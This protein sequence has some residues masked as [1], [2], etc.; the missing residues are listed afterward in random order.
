MRL[1]PGLVKVGILLLSLAFT[2]MLSLSIASLVLPGNLRVEVPEEADWNV[3]IVGDLLILE[4]D[5]RIYNGADQDITGFQ[6]RIR[7]NDSLGNVIADQSGD[8]YDLPSGTWTD[9][10]VHLDL[11]LGQMPAETLGQLTFGNGSLGVGVQAGASYFFRLIHVDVDVA[12]Q[13]PVG[14][15]IHGL[16]VDT[17]AATLGRLGQEYA[18]AVPFQFEAEDLLV[19]QEV[20]IATILTNSTSSLG[21][22]MQTVALGPVT[23]GELLVV[24]SGDAAAHLA[25]EEDELTLKVTIQFLDARMTLEY[26]FHWS[27]QEAAP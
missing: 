19:G 3:Q 13:V 11:D 26:R 1:A 6:I 16:Q 12:R 18:V 14:P 23:Q 25:S 21:G 10:A 24:L 9:V 4:T 15:L 22:G 17:A 5:L 8:R 20:E 27:P 7:V 2:L